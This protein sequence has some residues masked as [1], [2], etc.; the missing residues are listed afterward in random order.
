M[1]YDLPLVRKAYRWSA[2]ARLPFLLCALAD[3]LRAATG[4]T[5]SSND[6]E[7]V[8]PGAHSWDTGCKKQL[9]PIEGC[10][11]EEG[12][13]RKP[14]TLMKGFTAQDG[15]RRT[16]V[17]YAVYRNRIVSESFHRFEIPSLA[18]LTPTFFL[19]GPRGLH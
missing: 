3:I 16:F 10:T 17:T 9:G 6:D 15:V 4:I 5:L 7:F 11:Y 19:R 1:S 8:L 12:G 18:S 2:K 13:V 14:L